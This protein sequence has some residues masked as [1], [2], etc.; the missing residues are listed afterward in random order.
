LYPLT[1]DFEFALAVPTTQGSPTA[2][3]LA[4]L[5]K[6][7]QL[8][9]AEARRVSPTSRDIELIT[10]SDASTATAPELLEVRRIELDVQETTTG[11]DICFTVHFR[12]IR[13]IWGL[14]GGSAWAAFVPFGGLAARFGVGVLVSFAYPLLMQRRV[15][16]HLRW[17][18]ADIE[19][20]YR[21]SPP[22]AT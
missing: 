7:F 11:L 3:V 9:G 16:A 14:L 22:V 8:M 2:G 17:L 13:A 20:S 12:P 18:C 6:H 5:D 21:D 10:E 15:T 1:T 4:W 19:R